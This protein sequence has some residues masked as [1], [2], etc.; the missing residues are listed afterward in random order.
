MRLHW[1]RIREGA[2]D[3]A[4]MW[5]AGGDMGG[6]MGRSEH[7]QAVQSHQ[8]EEQGGDAVLG[9]VRK[10]EVDERWGYEAAS[11][12]ARSHARPAAVQK[13]QC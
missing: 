12:A 1:D 2:E 4:D 7:V 8:V 5:R 6:A 11:R 13:R 10:Q 9:A 3:Q